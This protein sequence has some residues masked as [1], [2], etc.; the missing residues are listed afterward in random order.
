MPYDPFVTVSWRKRLAFR[1]R[2]TVSLCRRPL[3]PARIQPRRSGPPNLLILAV[4]TL[5]YDHLGL[6]GYRRDLT[7]HLDAMARE[8]VCFHDV[9]AAAP[10]TLPSFASALTGVLPSV[11]GA[12]LEDEVRNMDEQPPH[13]LRRG[14][15]TLASHLRGLGYRTAAF[16]ANPFFAFGL[17]ESFA[18]H[19]YHNLPA[20]ELTWLALEWIRRHADRP[21][22]CFVL[23]NDPHEPTTP[24]RQELQPLLRELASQDIRPTPG[25]LRALIR[26]GNRGDPDIDLGRA[27][28]PLSTRIQDALAVKIALYDAAIAHVDA[29]VGRVRQ[30]LARWDLNANTIVTV[31]ADHGEE[32]LDHLAE[33]R[34]WDHDPRS[35]W[36]IG[37][38]HSQFQELLH[39]P[40]LACGPDIP[41]GVA[42]NDPVSLCDLTPTLLDWLQVDPLSMSVNVPAELQGSSRATPRQSAGSDRF[43]VAENTAYGPDLVAL[44][45]G[46][47]KLVATRQGDALGLYN[48][49]TDRGEKQDLRLHRRDKLAELVQDLTRWRRIA[50]QA[51]RG[52][53][54]GQGWD[55]ISTTVRRRLQELGY[56]D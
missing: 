39:V 32:F 5:R 49:A 22:C 40:W 27:T 30:Q 28:L 51:G 29:M 19:R 55:D 31:F 41:S 13:R 37:H 21:F 20:A 8:G 52:G 38:G 11:H 1:L 12:T 46:P 3:A 17:A 42:V 25:Q 33:A 16:Y 43:L 26:W 34:Q 2:Q 15:P 56:T 23:W 45:R 50:K 6:A 14:M 53:A 24:P 7:P 48:L 36:A 44:R 35:I 54:D 9:L 47:W 10:W 18:H 4:D